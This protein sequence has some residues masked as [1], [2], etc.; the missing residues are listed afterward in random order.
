M[1]TLTAPMAAP[2]STVD[3]ASRAAR[4]SAGPMRTSRAAA[5]SPIAASEVGASGVT[6]TTWIRA[7]EPDEAAAAHDRLQVVLAGGGRRRE[8]HDR[9]HQ[10]AGFAPD[11]QTDRGV[12]DR[13]GEQPI[14]H[15]LHPEHAPGH[16]DARPGADRPPARVP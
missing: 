7:T 3:N 10:G 11:E 8:S 5:P 15:A 16:G 14:G 6:P 4:S 13:V 2:T 12:R 9:R 1:P